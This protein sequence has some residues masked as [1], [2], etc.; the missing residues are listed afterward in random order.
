MA[1]EGGWEQPLCS[2]LPLDVA[3]KAAHGLEARLRAGWRV[4]Q[5]LVMTRFLGRV[6]RRALLIGAGMAALAALPLAGRLPA[7]LASLTPAVRA[8]EQG[9]AVLRIG[10]IPDQKR[11][12][13][14]NR[15]FSVLSQFSLTTG[16]A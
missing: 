8:A 10:A 9:V 4:V 16:Q 15:M 2:V 13:K 11:V 7:P 6:T 5:P 12:P 14:L 1:G 3:S